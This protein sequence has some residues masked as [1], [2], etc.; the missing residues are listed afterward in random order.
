MRAYG[1]ALILAAVGRVLRRGAVA[2]RVLF[3]LVIVGRV[4]FFGPAGAVVGR[5]LLFG[6][7][8]EA[9]APASLTGTWTIEATGRGGRGNFAGY[10][11]ATRMVIMELATEVTIQTN[12]GTENQLQTAVYKLDGS[13]NAV[14]GPIGWDT[15]AKAVRQDGKLIV[16][17]R[18]SIEG[19]DGRINFEI[20]D[21]YGVAGSVLT[22]ERSQ[23]KRT[24]RMIYNRA[25]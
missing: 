15:R 5:V 25:G 22:L 23:G 17:I 12:T 7:A 9:Q 2:A 16:T 4:L 18:R 21:V 13:E 10:S 24:R 19:P 14:P 11:T 20:R 8:V 1:L 6:P 3:A